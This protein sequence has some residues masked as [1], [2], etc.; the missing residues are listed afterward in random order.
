M[1]ACMINARYAALTSPDPLPMTEKRSY[2]TGE[3]V[4]Q[5]LLAAHKM[6]CINHIWNAEEHVARAI[7]AFRKQ[8]HDEH[9]EELKRVQ[10]RQVS[11]E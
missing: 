8:E 9:A 7:Y 5:S 6:V 1:T 3:A 10:T 11:D 2:F 4:L